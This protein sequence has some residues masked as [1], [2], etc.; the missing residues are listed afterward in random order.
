MDAP[1]MTS[2]GRRELA[3]LRS[4]AYGPDADIHR[5]AEALARLIELEAIARVD[6]P[7]AGPGPLDRRSRSAAAEPS[8]ESAPADTDGSVEPHDDRPR[9]RRTR[10]PRWAWIA[11]AAAVGLAAGLAVPLLSPP[12]PV[13]TLRQAPPADG[14]E[15]DFE[16]YG[17]PAGSPVSYEQFHDLQIWSAETEQGSTCVVVTTGAEE[18]MAAGC[19]PAPLTPTADILYYPG[20]RTID[21]LDL[22]DGS[23]IRFVLQGDVIE[24]WIAETD[25]SA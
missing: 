23:V 6:A 4:R 19:A 2:E 22:P 9:D 21:G 16:T 1:T 7:T 20:M 15:L 24:V 13:A 14:V 12:H 5:D 17:I 25:Q 8:T 10:I 18:W 3:E 11:G